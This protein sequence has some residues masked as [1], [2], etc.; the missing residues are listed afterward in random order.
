M[1]CWIVVLHTTSRGAAPALRVSMVNVTGIL[2]GTSFSTPGPD[3]ITLLASAPGL[4]FIGN[5][6]KETHIFNLSV[7]IFYKVSSYKLKHKA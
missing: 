2:A 7:Q 5:G 1:D 6:L 3:T 4:T